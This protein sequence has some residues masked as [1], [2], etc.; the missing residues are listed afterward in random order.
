MGAVWRMASFH[1]KPLVKLATMW[2]MLLSLMMVPGLAWA[3][4]MPYGV[5]NGTVTHV[6]DGDTLRLNT[7]H[8]VR[9]LDINTAEIA[10]EERPAEPLANQ[11]KMA[12][13][14]LA[15]GKPVQVQL[16]GR[17]YDPYNRVLGHV[18]L[19][20]GTRQAWVNGGLVQSGVA[21]VYTFP[22]NRVYGPELQRLEAAARSEK[23]GLWALPRWQVHDSGTCCA[24]T[25]IGRFVLVQGKVKTVA[26]VGNRTFLNFGDDWRTDFSVVIDRKQEKFFRPANKKGEKRSKAAPF[27]WNDYLGKTVLVRGVAQ[28]VNG[29]LVRV[30]H[31]EQLQ[32]IE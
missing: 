32:V 2:G 30:T 9:L 29:V 21:H 27:N 28:P 18:F 20:N 12:L 7:G 13:E 16:G 10:H 1:V 19:R 5:L 24:E 8:T 22:D 6:N 14:Q 11:A 25:D 17:V 15:L 3:Q 26:N 4:L 23:R 31:P